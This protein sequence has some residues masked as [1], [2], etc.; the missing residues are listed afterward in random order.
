MF[1]DGDKVYIE[2]QNQYGYVTGVNQA[3]NLVIFIG[4]RAGKDEY[5]VVHPNAARKVTVIPPA[6][7]SKMREW[8]DL[9]ESSRGPGGAKPTLDQY[10]NKLY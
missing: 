8:A 3:G 10:D 4:R 5:T 9:R 2:S 6:Y 7:E 1:G